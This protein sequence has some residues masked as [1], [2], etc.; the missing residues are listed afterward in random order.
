VSDK[1]GLWLHLLALGAY[2]GAT[3]LLMFLV[4]PA[5]R[6]LADAAARQT[7]LAACFRVYDPLAIAALGV[8]VMT[9]AFNLTSYKSALAGEFF[10][11]VGQYLVW[12]LVLV[13]ALVMVAT[14]IT[15]GLGHRIVRHEDWQEQLGA[16]RLGSLERRLRAPLVL[17]LGLTAAITWVSLGIPGR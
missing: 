4:L 3:L 17:A 10:A 8:Q 5:A 9:G 7:F 6:R 16:E 14:Y 2:F 1:I 15:F 11:R 13:F 12:K